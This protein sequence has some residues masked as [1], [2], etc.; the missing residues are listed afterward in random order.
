M[1]KGSF[2]LFSKIS[3]FFNYIATS[4]DK[5]IADQEYF[6][7][8]DDHDYTGKYSLI[9][10]A[11]GPY[12]NGKITGLKSASPND[13]LLDI[14]LIKSGGPLIPMWT[15]RR[16]AKGK[17]SK[18]CVFLRAK[19]ITIQSDKQMWMQ[20]DNE[21][22]RDTSITISVVHHAVQMVAVNDASY[23]V[24]EISGL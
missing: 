11:N 17:R 16:Y 19:K 8:I 3:N 18:N 6:L 14:A 5:E 22:F 21:Y 13:G 10:I 9:H 7:T 1:G 23:P 20:L 24:A 4:F 2:I 15:M 12:H